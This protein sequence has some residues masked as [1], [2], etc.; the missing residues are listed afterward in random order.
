MPMTNL[1]MRNYPIGSTY[2]PDITMTKPLTRSQ[3]RRFRIAR[4]QVSFWAWLFGII[5][6]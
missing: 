1:T 2:T 4:A 6:Y 3:L 5:K